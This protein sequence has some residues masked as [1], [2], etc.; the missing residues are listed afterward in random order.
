[1]PKRPT[2]ILMIAVDSLRRDHMSCYGYQRLTTPHLD[3]L[4]AGGVLFENMF[5]AYIPTTPG[6]ATMLTGRDVMATSQ[7]CLGAKHPLHPDQP[8]LPEIL[9][10]H[11]YVSTCVGFDGSF[12]RGF[13]KYEGYA[14]WG[15]W[16]DNPLRKAENLN[17]K[18]IPALEDMAGQPFLLFLRHMDPHTPYLP[19]PP[20]NQMFYSGDPC[21]KDNKSM[22]PVF[23]FKPFAD[24]FASWMPPG[25]TDINWALAMYDS[26]LAYMDTCIARLFA[27]LGELGLSENTLIVLT[28]DHGETLDEHD[29]WFDHHGTYEPTLRVP[30]VLYQPGNRQLPPG[31]RVKGYVLLEDI[32][33]TLLDLLGLKKDLRNIEFDGHS[34]MQLVRGKR[35][36]WRT[37]FY[38]TE[39]TW[40]RK[41]G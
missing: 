16:A 5:S 38:I 37:E 25:I 35:R 32:V 12:Y 26:E 2:N 4:A 13:D 41:R 6:Y 40:M 34:A 24:Y 30:L 27:R 3:Q 14:A 19:P 28:S 36:N 8:T 10:E 20:F 29:C 33:P 31:K 17:E 7:V 15:S 21:A 39:C 23:A 22:D 1:M 18:A 9:R 11:G